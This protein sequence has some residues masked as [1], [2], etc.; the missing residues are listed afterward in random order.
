MVAVCF[1][2]V[3]S[4]L[5]LAKGTKYASFVSIGGKCRHCEEA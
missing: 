3:L 1:A 4:K 2:R 5:V